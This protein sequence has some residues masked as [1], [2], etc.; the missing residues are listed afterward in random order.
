MLV[1]P[2]AFMITGIFFGITTTC[3][4]D[5][6]IIIEKVLELLARSGK[7]L[8]LLNSEAAVKASLSLT[9]L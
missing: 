4:I 9:V 8:E 1:L 2:T 5:A 6:L 3:I 7:H